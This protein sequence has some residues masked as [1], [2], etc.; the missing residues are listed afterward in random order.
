MKK[1]K[2]K[3]EVCAACDGSGREPY[4]YGDWYFAITSWPCRWCK[5]TGHKHLRVCKKSML[6]RLRIR[7]AMVL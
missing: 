1:P 2:Q 7:A 3:K 6:R 5:G 4:P